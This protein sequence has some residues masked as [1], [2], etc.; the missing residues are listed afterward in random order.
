MV[1]KC[2]GVPSAHTHRIV[3][4]GVVVMMKRGLLARGT[5]RGSSSVS[6]RRNCASHVEKSSTSM[7]S[8][9]FHRGPATVLNHWID[10]VHQRSISD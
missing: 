8:P 10:Q 1:S 6:R 4:G 3:S 2:V 5:H 9:L 7:A